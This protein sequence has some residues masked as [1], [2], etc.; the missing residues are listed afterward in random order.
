MRAVVVHP[1]E[2]KAI[3]AI[4]LPEAQSAAFGRIQQIVG[5]FI[6][7]VRVTKDMVM[8]ID[9]M[10]RSQNLTLNRRVGDLYVHGIVGTVVLVGVTSTDDGEEYVSIPAQWEDHFTD[11]ETWAAKDAL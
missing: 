8:L 5:G 3:E 9:E 6:E 7:S 1:D 11:P 2:T 10:G 4:N